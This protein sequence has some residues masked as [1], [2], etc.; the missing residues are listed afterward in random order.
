MRSASVVSASMAERTPVVM[1]AAKAPAGPGIALDD[2][3]A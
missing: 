3:A 1:A 2:L